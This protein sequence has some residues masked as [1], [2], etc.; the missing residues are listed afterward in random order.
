MP[1]PDGASLIRATNKTNKKGS[2]TPADAWAYGCIGGCSARSAERARLSA[3]HHGACCSERTPQLSSRYAL[4]GTWSD[5]RSRWFER[6]RALNGRYPLL[7]VPVQRVSSQTGHHAGRA[8]FP[9]AAR[10]RR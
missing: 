3:F 10:E 7:P 8:Y 5:T 4:P 9:E 6:S 1:I 2:G